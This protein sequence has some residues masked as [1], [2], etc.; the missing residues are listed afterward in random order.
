MA[1]PLPKIIDIGL[2]KR[3]SKIIILPLLLASLISQNGL[4][5]QLFNLSYEV[6]I[7]SPLLLVVLDAVV[8]VFLYTIVVGIP[9]WILH[10]LL[11]IIHFWTYS[12]KLQRS[13]ISVVPIIPFTLAII[14][15]IGS[16]KVFPLNEIGSN[17]YLTLFV[18]GFYLMAIE[19]DANGEKS[20]EDNN[21]YP[22]RNFPLMYNEK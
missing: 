20:E 14:G 17:W 12:N 6:N 3:T 16:D 5:I 8:L 4:F 19:D 7:N 11:P 18:F 1:D 10:N 22:K 9:L 2:L 21:S 15:F 13:I